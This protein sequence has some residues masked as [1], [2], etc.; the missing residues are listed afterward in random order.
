M[1]SSVRLQVST[2]FEL[3]IS[4]TL[5]STSLEADDSTKNSVTEPPTLLHLIY[6]YC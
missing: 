1:E 6:T 4:W 5:K 2:D 3:A